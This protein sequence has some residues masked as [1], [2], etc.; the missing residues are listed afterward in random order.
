MEPLIKAIAL[1]IW[2][3]EEAV[4]ALG[5]LG[6][7]RAIK[8]LLNRACNGSMPAAEALAH[9][10]FQDA[11]VP[12]IEALKVHDPQVR[13]NAAKSLGRLGNLQAVAPLIQALGD[14]LLEV[15][16]NVAHALGELGDASS[17]KYLRKVAAKDRSK[18][19]QQAAK[20]ALEKVVK[21]NPRRANALS[22][23]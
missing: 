16:E 5:C 11:G 1:G 12:L 4:N 8:P 6:D 2:G 20:N 14:R 18:V 19:V 3:S 7:D 15:R 21:Q 13:K 17:I 9:F 10:D 22:R 23:K